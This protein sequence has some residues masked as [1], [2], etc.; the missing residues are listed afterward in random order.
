MNEHRIRPAW[1]RGAERPTP[2]NYWKGADIARSP[3]LYNEVRAYLQWA[4]WCHRGLDGWQ[5]MRDETRLFPQ[6]NVITVCGSRPVE[7]VLW[8]LDLKCS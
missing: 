6:P 1:R 3:S 7:Y 2:L 8:T 4:N 5:T